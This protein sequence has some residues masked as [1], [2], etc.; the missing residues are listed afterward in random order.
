MQQK[1]KDHDPILL[2]SFKYCSYVKLNPWR[3]GNNSPLKNVIL[4]SP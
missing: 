1:G 2:N 4:R 3:V